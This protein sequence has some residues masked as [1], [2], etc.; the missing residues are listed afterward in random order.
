MADD[1][2]GGLGSGAIPDRSWTPVR[3]PSHYLPGRR[4]IV[5][6]AYQDNHPGSQARA[7]DPHGV[8][9]QATASPEHPAKARRNEA[10]GFAVELLTKSQPKS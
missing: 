5:A 7:A 4:L 2:V 8:A 10:S 3:Q 9:A 6:Y 1:S